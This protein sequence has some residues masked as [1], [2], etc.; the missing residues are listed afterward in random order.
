MGRG[1]GSRSRGAPRGAHGIGSR[2]SRWL[3]AALLLAIVPAGSQAASVTFEGLPVGSD[4]ELLDLDGVSI[5]GGIVL[6]EATVEVLTGFPAAGTWNTTPGG[7]Q[8]LLNVLAPRL[9]VTFHAPVRS[10]ALHA[11]TLP[12]AAGAPAALALLDANGDPWLLFEPD[13]PGD[14]GFP[15]HAISVGPL[16]GQSFTGFTLCLADRTSGA[17]LEPGLTTSIWI[18]DLVFEPVPAPAALALTGL[19]LVAAAWR[20]RR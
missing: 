11:L 10:F 20:S 12:D 6:D 15:E 17:C 2:G 4:A 7:A 16:A 3:L 14:S 8:G 13:A 1:D 19:G 5:S 9:T 18:D